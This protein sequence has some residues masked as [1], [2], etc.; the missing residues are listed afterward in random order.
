[1]YPMFQ[2]GFE[3]LK[4]WHFLENESGPSHFLASSVDQPLGTKLCCSKS[5]TETIMQAKTHEHSL[6]ELL[7]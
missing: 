1:M 7:T 5:L 3:M 2:I 6:S 4:Y